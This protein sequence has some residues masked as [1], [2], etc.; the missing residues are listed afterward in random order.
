[1]NTGTK[2]VVNKDMQTDIIGSVILKEEEELDR[3]IS[4]LESRVRNYNGV[5]TKY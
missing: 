3:I 4:E 2:E 5:I 1:M